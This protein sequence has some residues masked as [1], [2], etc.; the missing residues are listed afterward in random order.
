MQNFENFIW[1]KS[2]SLVFVYVPKVA[3][4]NWKCVMRYLEGYE[5]YLDSRKAH[6]RKLG[7]LT[8]LS[9][10]EDRDRILADT[11]IPKFSFVRN[12]YTRILSAY[13]NKVRPFALDGRGPEW[14]A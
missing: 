8:Y 7:G 10:C 11:N 4:T 3:C 6:D 1:V 12:P 13:L 5:D 14:D 9:Q 2:R